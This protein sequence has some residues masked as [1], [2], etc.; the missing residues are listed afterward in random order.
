MYNIVYVFVILGLYEIEYMLEMIEQIIRLMGFFD[1]FIDVCLIEG[2]IDD[3]IG[4]IQVRIECNEC[5][6]VMIL[7]KKMLEDLIDYLKEIGIKV[8]YF[9]LEIKMFEWIEIICDFCF[10]K[11]DVLIGINLLREGFDILEVLFVVILDV[12][13]EGFFCFEW[14]L[15]QMIGWVVWNVE[16]CVIM[17]VDKIMYLMEIVINEMKCWWEQQECF[18]EIYGIML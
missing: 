6:F 4:E 12:D 9:Y 2:Q 15:I 11:Y 5:V 14:L 8:N 3:L 10:G 17:Y 13:K 7:I 1:F 18:N 16:G